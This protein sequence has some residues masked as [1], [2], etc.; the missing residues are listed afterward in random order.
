MKSWFFE[1]VNKTDKRLARLTKR[2]E[3]TE[4]NKI[5]NEKGVPVVAQWLMNPTGIPEDV[6]S[7][8]GLAHSVG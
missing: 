6:G 1:K 3:R 7:I 2:S 8:P 5:R 4:I